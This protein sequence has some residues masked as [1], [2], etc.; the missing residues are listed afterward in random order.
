[1]RASITNFPPVTVG[2]DAQ[3]T[4]GK[5]FHFMVVISTRTMAI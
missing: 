5:N 1:M 4:F 2:N 3:E